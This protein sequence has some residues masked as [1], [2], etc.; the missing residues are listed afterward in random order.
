MQI[1]VKKSSMTFLNF[2]LGY[3]GFVYKEDKHGPSN[4][5]GQP[6]SSLSC[7]TGP[8]ARVPGSCLIHLRQATLLHTRPL[9]IP[10]HPTWLGYNQLLMVALQTTHPLAGLLI[11]PMALLQPFL[12]TVNQC[13][14]LVHY[15]IS[16]SF[17][18]VLQHYYGAASDTPTHGQ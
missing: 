2:F 12:P 14:Q 10:L 8:L 5:L 3:I 16:P 7:T 11:W 18:V 1:Q 15:T 4:F 13:N 9:V 17:G 6:S